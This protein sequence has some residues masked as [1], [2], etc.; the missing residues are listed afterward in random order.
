MRLVINRRTSLRKG[1]VN[2]D[3]LKDKL[4]NAKNLYKVFFENAACFQLRNK[5]ATKCS[6]AHKLS[7]LKQGRYY[8]ELNYKIME[9]KK[10]IF[11]C[12]SII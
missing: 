3:I 11:S 7:L 12:K 4:I 1:A 5:G 2:L 8:N 9:C 6:T 10:P